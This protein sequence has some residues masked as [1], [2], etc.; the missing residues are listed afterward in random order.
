MN[1]FTPHNSSRFARGP[2]DWTIFTCNAMPRIGQQSRSNLKR[3]KLVRRSRE[4]NLGGIYDRPSCSSLLT[5]HT[6]IYVPDESWTRV[7]QNARILSILLSKRKFILAIRELI[8]REVHARASLDLPAGWWWITWPASPR[9]HPVVPRRKC[10][11]R[12]HVVEETVRNIDAQ[13]FDWK[14]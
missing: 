2:H 13:C 3:A 14:C 6:I 1:L 9:A 8:S 11:V 10:F 7:R 5:R 4:D 12:F